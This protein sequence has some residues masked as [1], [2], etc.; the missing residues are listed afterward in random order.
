M[1]EKDDTA[2]MILA[3]FD[4]DLYQQVNLDRSVHRQKCTSTEVYNDALLRSILEI[5]T[6]R[7]CQVLSA[8]GSAAHGTGSEKV[9][10]MSDRFLLGLLSDFKMLGFCS[11]FYCSWFFL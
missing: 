8:Y 3:H 2:K 7:W 9:G 10:N 6:G 11:K 5:T 1:D 4:G